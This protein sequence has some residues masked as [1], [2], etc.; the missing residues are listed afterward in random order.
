MVVVLGIVVVVVVV[1][2]FIVP[3]MH[4][5]GRGKRIGTYPVLKLC[6]LCV[7]SL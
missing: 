1:V 5:H 2:D 7:M 4:G 3:V 6:A